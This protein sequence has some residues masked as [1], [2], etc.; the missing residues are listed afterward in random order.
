MKIAIGK[1]HEAVM[2]DVGGKRFIMIVILGRRA[3]DPFADMSCK[4]KTEEG[5]SLLQ[6]FINFVIAGF[7]PVTYRLVL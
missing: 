7:I 5:C 3:E 4:S 2:T 6:V 1:I